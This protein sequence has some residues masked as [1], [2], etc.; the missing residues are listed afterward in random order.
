MLSLY[1]SSC[2]TDAAFYSI[3]SN[4]IQPTR[5][6]DPLRYH[7]LS[8]MY[9]SWV[10]QVPV[11]VL[12]SLQIS[13]SPELNNTTAHRNI[14]QSLNAV[15]TNSSS[16]KRNASRERLHGIRKK[17]KKT[18]DPEKVIL[19]FLRNNYVVAI[20]I[21]N[22]NLK[23]VNQKRYV[24]E[25]ASRKREVIQT[26]SHKGHW[27]HPEGRSKCDESKPSQVAVGRFHDAQSGW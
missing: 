13:T 10:R 23:F 5:N 18:F 19:T 15:A 9:Q 26:L 4:T 6:E 17:T 12:T 24:W 2:N 22:P 8:S 11:V 21:K 3:I 16:A 25:L 27:T 7:D 14:K 1:S 20:N